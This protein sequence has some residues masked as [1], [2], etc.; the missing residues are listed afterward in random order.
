VYD[1]NGF[2]VIRIGPVSYANPVTGR[3]CFRYL[4]DTIPAHLADTTGL[5]ITYRDF[6]LQALGQLAR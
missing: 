6:S 5:R 2:C 1:S 4:G 3:G